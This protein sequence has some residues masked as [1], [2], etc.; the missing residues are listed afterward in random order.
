[1]TCQGSHSQT[2]ASGGDVDGLVI[3]RA[4]EMTSAGVKIISTEIIY[5]LM[6]KCLSRHNRSQKNKEKTIENGKHNTEGNSS[7]KLAY[8]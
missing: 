3:D 1:M 7:R 4:P 6:T 8:Q 5:K 2:K